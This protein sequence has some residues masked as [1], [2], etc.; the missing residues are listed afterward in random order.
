MKDKGRKKD[1]LTQAIDV[2]QSALH[3]AAI[4]GS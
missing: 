3:A 4:T 1:T 2:R